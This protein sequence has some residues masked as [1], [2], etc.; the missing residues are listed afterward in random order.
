[1]KETDVFQ[2][3]PEFETEE[4]AASKWQHIFKIFMYVILSKK[5]IYQEEM[6][7]FAFMTKRV[8]SILSP[9]LILTDMMLKDWFMLNREE[10]MQRVLIGQ[11][12][13]AVQF[14]M[15][16]LDEVEDK[17]TIIR[18]MQSIAKCDGDLQSDERRLITYVAQQWRYA[19]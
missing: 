3:P 13:R 11:E 8:K 4:L 17:I 6:A 12:E 9:N 5:R 18:A 1:M 7:M 2:A 14:H 19:A 15:D 10:V 16:H